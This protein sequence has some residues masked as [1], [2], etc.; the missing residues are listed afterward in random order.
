MV[1]GKISLSE[2]R[3]LEKQMLEAPGGE[4]WLKFDGIDYYTDWGYAF[5]GIRYFLQIIERKISEHNGC[6]LNN[7]KKKGLNK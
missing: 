4:T 1:D 5:E 6:L 2:L 7:N 3:E